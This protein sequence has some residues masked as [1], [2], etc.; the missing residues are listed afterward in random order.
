MLARRAWRSF[1]VD[2]SAARR[3]ERRRPHETQALQAL[4]SSLSRGEEDQKLNASRAKCVVSDQIEEFSKAKDGS[5]RIVSVGRVKVGELKRERKG[6][7]A[8]AEQNEAV[9]GVWRAG[10]N[11]RFRLHS[12]S[13]PSLPCQRPHETVS[14]S[15]RSFDGTSQVLNTFSL[16]SGVSPLLI[17]A[18]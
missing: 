12:K 4:R 2:I 16:H 7:I 1:G 13:R 10:G 11:C 17:L 5:L 18:S 14:T 6:R 9:A 8:E 3:E 15:I